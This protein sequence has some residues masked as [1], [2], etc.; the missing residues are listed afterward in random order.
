MSITFFLVGGLIFATYMYFTIWNIFNSQKKSKRENYPN[1][2]S[3]GCDLPYDEPKSKDKSNL[4]E[5]LD[6]D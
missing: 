5:V 3:E 2:G 1:L 6:I 4:V